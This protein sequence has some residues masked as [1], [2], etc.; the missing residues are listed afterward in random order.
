MTVS[1]FLLAHWSLTIVA[2]ALVGIDGLRRELRARLNARS[3]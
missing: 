1:Q 2:F 3:R